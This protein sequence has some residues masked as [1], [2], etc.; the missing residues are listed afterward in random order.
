MNVLNAVAQDLT[1]T[2]AGYTVK[3]TKSHR[4]NTY[5]ITLTGKDEASVLNLRKLVDEKLAG[6]GI[7]NDVTYTLTQQ[8]GRVKS[9]VTITL[10]VVNT[11]ILTRNVAAPTTKA[12][13]IASGLKDHLQKYQVTVGDWKTNNKAGLIEI[14]GVVAGHN[15]KN[16]QKAVDVIN[17]YYKQYGQTKN[18]TIKEGTGDKEGTV[19]I[20]IRNVVK[21][22]AV[23]A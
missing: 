9:I 7:N 23:A 15:G 13:T 1:K 3:L 10:K 22:E 14:Y 4:E 18:V 8:V 12:V 17:D 19:N 5:V 20:R 21:T 6:R 2:A 16:A 11:E